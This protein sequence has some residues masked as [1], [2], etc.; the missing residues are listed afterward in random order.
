MIIRCILLVVHKLPAIVVATL[1]FLVL[2]GFT[3]SGLFIFKPLYAI[4]F[5]RHGV[6]E[7][8]GILSGELGEVADAFVAYFTSDET[9][10]AVVVDVYGVE[11]SLLSEKEA[12]HMRDVKALV[13]N[14][15]N[16]S[17]VS[18]I[19][20]IGYVAVLSYKARVRAIPVL[21][22]RLRKSAFAIVV[23]TI[24]FALLTALAFPA[25]FTLFHLISFSNDYWILDP[26]QDYLV[27]LFTPN[28]FLEATGLLIGLILL[29]C[30]VL[31]GV[32]YVV[33][34]KRV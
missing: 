3:V 12:I 19:G 34:T 24:L 29:E 8:T 23:V 25:L 20:I 26:R 33:G 30:A 13:I 15:R 14:L 10:M 22:L 2:L 5:E 28:F 31:I 21:T 32:S 27:M 9:Y 17:I 16:L 1:L 7:A 18:L 6:S 4:G 11:R